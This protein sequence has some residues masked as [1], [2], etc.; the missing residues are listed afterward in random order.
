MSKGKTLPAS[1]Q[2]RLQPFI[3]KGI[4]NGIFSDNQPVVALYRRK[5]TE[6]KDTVVELGGMKNAN[7]QRFVA[8]CVMT[9]LSAMLRQKSYIGH[10]DIWSC[11]S[12]TTRTGRQMANIFGQVVIEDGDSAMDSALFKMSLWDEDAGLA[13][14]IA[15]GVTYSAS[16]SCKNLDMEIL[17]LRPLSGMTVFVEEEYEHSDRQQLLRD[18]YEVTPIADLEENISRNRN[19]FRMVEATVSYAGVQTSKTGNAFGKMLLKD[20]S[21][22]TI[23]AIESGEG[24]MLNALCDTETANRFGKYS[25]VLALVTTSMSDQY[26]LSSNIQAAVGI[27][28]IAP[29]VVVAPSSGDDAEDNASD[30]FKADSKVETITLD[31]DEDDTPAV[32]E[33]VVEEVVVEEAAPEAKKPADEPKP[34]LKEGDAGWTAEGDD[35]D[36]DDDWD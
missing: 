6:L 11:D 22:M 16:I 17:D 2:K 13:D 29:P 23:E 1:V 4:Q 30:Y 10:L 15:S 12:R 5:A 21:T 28:T 35:E 25:E 3:D 24:L 20:E 26:G 18:T 8:N 33:T 32:E 7:A 9:D 14:D 19:D 31:E 34:A 36:W 27:V